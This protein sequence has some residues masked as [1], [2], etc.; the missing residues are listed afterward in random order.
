MKAKEFILTDCPICE[1]LKTRNE[2]SFGKLETQYNYNK[3]TTCGE[4]SCIR[5][6]RKRQEKMKGWVDPVQEAAINAFVYPAS[7]R[8]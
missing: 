7:I 2:Y 8:S 5:E 6:F 3:R 4:Y 1:T